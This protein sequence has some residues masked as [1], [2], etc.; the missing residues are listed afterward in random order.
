[1]PIPRDKNQ[2]SSMPITTTT[3]TKNT[4]RANAAALEISITSTS[5]KSAAELAAEQAKK[6]SQA[7]KNAL[8]VWHT[9]ST[10]DPTAITAAGAKEA[11]EKEARALDGIGIAARTKEEEDK[12]AAAAEGINGVQADGNNCIFVG[13]LWVR[14]LNLSSYRGVL[15]CSCCAE[16]EGR[17]RRGRGRRR[18]R[19]RG[20]R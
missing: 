12:K 2:L 18:G 14:V 4:S 7:E 1:M 15:C 16:G 13:V 17:G 11:A 20:G 3:S 8:P 6:Q 10:V 9:Q 5:D 19:R